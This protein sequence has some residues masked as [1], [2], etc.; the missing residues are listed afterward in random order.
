MK[1]LLL[2]LA[3]FCALHSSFAA[4]PNIVL[5]NIDDLG[6]ADIGPFGA[7][8]STPNLDRMAKEGMKLMSHYAAPV[9]SPS[10]A[11]MMTGCYP[12]RVL[13]I[14][15]VLFPA[16]AVGLNPNATTVAEVLKGAG[17]ATACIGKWH[18]GDQPEFL[19]T[20]QGFDSYFG[21]PYSNDMGPAAEGSK[22]NPDKP[23]PQSNPKAGAG[24]GKGDAE[25]ETGL[26]GN[27]Q[28]PLPLVENHN[29]VERVK[30]EQHHTFTKRY[31]ERAV[32]FIR[33]HEKQPFFLYLPHNAVHFPHYPSKDFTGKSGISLQKDWAMEV[34]WSVGQ[35]LDTL[36]ELKLDANT[37]V[38]FTSDNGGP[39]NQGADNTPLRGSKGS[40]LEGGIRVCTIAWWPGKIAAGSETKDITAHMDWLPTFGALAKSK[41]VGELKLDGKDISPVLL[42]KKEAKGHDV[43]HYYSGFN[44]QAVRSGPWKLH[45]GSKELY[46]LEEDIGEA[47]NVAADHADIVEKLQ[48]LAEKMKA[49][50][51]DK[52]NNAPGVRA[53]GRVENP[54]P[55]IGADGTVR[56]G[57]NQIAK[58]LP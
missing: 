8:I 41:S 6:Y 25:P 30:V 31:T 48:K 29:V 20:N 56:E 28:P 15:G 1:P 26:K 22:S 24:K 55:L 10:R 12:K 34:D 47:K 57:F 51:G 46:H 11:A 58:T 13:P 33:E 54:Q 21:I 45:L 40:T 39:L 35:V 19:P 50:L 42:G 27:A 38:I 4:T 7:K 53:L 9:C 32:K 17:Y 2:L 36:R 49:D 18:L 44:L 3:S 5:I 52:T 23:L 43:F 14:P 16:A 37:L